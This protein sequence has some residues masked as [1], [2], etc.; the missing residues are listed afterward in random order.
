MI[1]ALRV[2]TEAPLPVTAGTVRA[3]GPPAGRRAPPAKRLSAPKTGVKLKPDPIPLRRE[4]SRMPVP[5]GMRR[6]RY[7]VFEIKE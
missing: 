2:V 6:P 1:E 5:T 3:D 7:F 4:N